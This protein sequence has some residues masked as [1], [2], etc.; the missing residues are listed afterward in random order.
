M[1]RRNLLK[2]GLAV[3]LIVA[4][5]GGAATQAPSGGASVGGKLVIANASGSTWSC[6]FNPFNPS[7]SGTSIGFVYEPLQFVNWLQQNTDGSNKVT[8][9]LATD[10]SWSSDFKTLTFTIRSGVKWSDGQDFTVD[11]VVYTFNALKSDPAMDLNALWDPSGAGLTGVAAQGSD[12]VVLTF[13]NPA[14][15]YFY[16][17]ADQIPMIPKHVFSSEDQ[18]KLASLPVAS[19]VGTGP[20]KMAACAE[21]NIK[22]L[23]NETYWQ[24]TSSNPVPRIAEVDYPSYLSNDPCN[25]D[26]AEG[27]AQWGAQYI[28][29]IDS[30]YIKGNANRH[31]WFPPIANVAVF[32]NNENAL[33]SNKAVRQAMAWAID[34]AD[35]STRGESGYQ[36]AANQTGIV[37]PTFQSWYDQSLDTVKFDV[38]TAK[39]LLE[40]AGFTKGSDG[41]YK[42]AS[43]KRL[44]FTIKSISGYT[45]WDSSIQVI[46]QQLKAAGIEI[47]NIIDE[48]IGVYTTDLQQ[49]NYELAYGEETGGPLP[50]YEM[51][52]WLLSGNIGSTNYSRFKSD[53]VDKLFAQYA[54]A[55]AADQQKII[56][57]LSQVMVDQVPLIPVTEGVAWYQ[58]DT[59]NFD[60]WPTKDNPY[61][62][63]AVWATPDNMVVLTHLFPK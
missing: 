11:D 57:Q 56:K 34:R 26:L 35:V 36:P 63:P 61:A 23:R 48:D 62:L 25:L 1:G 20:Y 15:T 22:Y 13:A 47:S 12:K 53:S 49:G 44:S 5:C 45:D 18:T 3:S 38:A 51:R 52:Q 14:Q 43:G 21:N 10:S 24:S 33:L 58:Y 54:T 60:G 4:G 55:S 8:P 27:K 31:Y 32:M 40:G 17:V 19:P 28:P 2:L 46:Q 9:W 39:S 7:V 37:I 30:F 29:N 16:Y 50:Y 41:I 59:T 6:Q 42:D